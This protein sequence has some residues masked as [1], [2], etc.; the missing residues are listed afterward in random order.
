MAEVDAAA[1]VE[2]FLQSVSELL[3]QPVGPD[4]GGADPAADNAENRAIVRARARLARSRA[5]ALG[6]RL[7][8]LGRRHADFLAVHRHDAPQRSAAHHRA[9]GMLMGMFGLTGKQAGE[10][11]AMLSWQQDRPPEALARRMVTECERGGD[12]ANVLR[13]GGVTGRHSVPLVVRRAVAFI[14]R[15]AHEDITSDHIATAAGVGRRRLQHA[16]REHCGV[17]PTRYLRR[18]R[19]AHA[20]RELLAA[21]PT[22]GDTVGAIADA[23]Q[24]PHH[25]RFAVEYRAAYGVTPATTLH[26]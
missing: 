11:L 13:D 15:H 5:E 8:D 1:N 24:L 14:E 23:W 17:S 21:D 12:P 6:E 18:V 4:A 19:L 9:V 7:E 22:R 16:F 2:A 10:L 25:G 26:R 3:A 20:H